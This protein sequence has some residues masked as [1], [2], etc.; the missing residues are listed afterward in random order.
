METFL[1]Y[2]LAVFS[3]VYLLV[4]FVVPSVRVYK[5]T[6]VNPVT[7]GSSDSAHDYVGLVMKLL[8]V[9]LLL[10]VLT[11]SFSSKLYSYLNPFSY[12]SHDGFKYAGL[13]ISHLA[14]VWIIVAQAQMKQSWRIGIDEKNKTELITHGLFSL[15]RNPVFLGIILTTTGIFFIIPNA[16]TLLVAV[17]SY[18]I[19]QV[20]IRLEEAHLL[21]AH[22][23]DYAMYKR[24]VRRLI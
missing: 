10:S 19:I 6:G 4:A 15:S 17:C 14:L 11:Y 5:Q 9:L 12:L 23:A 7:F 2:Y 1:K 21:V 24:R 3:L 22:G 20:Q 8:T 13:F 16:I 18:L